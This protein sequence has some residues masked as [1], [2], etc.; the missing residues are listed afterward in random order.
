MTRRKPGG[1]L[2]VLALALLPVAALPLLAGAQPVPADQPGRPSGGLR[3]RYGKPQQGAKIE[4]AVR[5]FNSDDAETRIEG[6]KALGSIEGERKATDYLLQAAND[7]DMRI[8]IKAIDVLGNAHTKDATPLLVQQLFLR[9]TD[10]ATKQHILASLGKIGDV[11]ATSPILDFLN[12]DVDPAVRGSAI[13]A[14]GDIADRAAVAPLEA[15]ARDGHDPTLR[16]LAEQAVQKIQQRPA[17]TMVPPALAVD[18]RGPEGA[19]P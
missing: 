3:D 17:P 13:F 19:R 18:R 15:F 7:P 9:D 8:R 14:L 11:R 2:A 16:R 6:V 4:E 5:K 1:G 12:R 10:A